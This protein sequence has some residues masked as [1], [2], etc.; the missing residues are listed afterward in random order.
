MTANPERER[1]AE[2]ARLPDRLTARI[3][4]RRYSLLRTWWNDRCP[5]A[6]ARV[7]AGAATLFPVL[8]CSVVVSI[9]GVWLGVFLDCLWALTSLARAPFWASRCSRNLDAGFGWCRWLAA[10]PSLSGAPAC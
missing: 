9:T 8:L 2:S 3:T 4:T 5:R 7:I 1:P 10:G 6:D